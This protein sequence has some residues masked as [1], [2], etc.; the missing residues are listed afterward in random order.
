MKRIFMSIITVVAFASANAQQAVPI[1]D[2]TVEQRD[3]AFYSEQ[4]EAW[5]CKVDENPK[6]SMAWRNLYKAAHYM[7]DFYKG[8]NNPAEVVARLKEALPDSYTYYYCAYREKQGTEESFKMAEEALKRLPAGDDSD[9]EIWTCYFMMLGNDAR[10]APA[11]ARYYESGR[12]SPSVLQY[13]YNE[14]QGMQKGGIY[15]GNGDALVIPKI[16]LQYGKHV[17]EDKIVVC[18]PFLHVDRYRNALFQRLGIGE[19]PAEPVYSSLADCDAYLELI[20][21]TIRERSRRPMYFGGMYAEQLVPSWKKHLY[22]EGLTV[23]YSEVPYNNR[24]VKQTNVEER[25]MMEYLKEH[26]YPDTWETSSNLSA[27]YAVML[28]DLL[29]MYKK[30]GNITRYRWLKSLLT[31]GVQNTSL[32]KDRKTVFLQ[33]I[34]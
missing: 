23:K 11:A 5:G 20:L 25:Y 16:L 22:N 4:I 32:P 2:I 28:C 7:G 8:K 3:S 9:I 30:S 34:K 1:K 21:R 26:F 13:N 24:A 6:D 27:N 14:L 18:A 29:P 31:T 17:H 19:P 10:L 15:V 33:F 12:Y